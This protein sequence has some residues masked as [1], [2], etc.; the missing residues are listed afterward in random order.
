MTL[1]LE[2]GFALKRVRDMIRTSIQLKKVVAERTDPLAV[3]LAV[4]L[5]YASCIRA[6]EAK[7]HRDCIQRFLSG[8]TVIAGPINYKHFI[9]SKNDRFNHFCDW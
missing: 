1:R 2:C 7:Y 8:V 4:K 9:S 3:E 6:E 5:S